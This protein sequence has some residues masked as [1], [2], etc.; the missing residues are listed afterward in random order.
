MQGYPFGKNP[1]RR[2][3]WTQLNS[4]TMNIFRNFDCGD[5][6]FISLFTPVNDTPGAGPS[7]WN[8]GVWKESKNY[9]YGIAF[10][11]LDVSVENFD[12][13]KNVPY[14]MSS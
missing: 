9:Q 3:H 14:A 11:P 10:F 1:H 8:G 6:F 5:E 13:E 12:T 2:T 4:E 7:C